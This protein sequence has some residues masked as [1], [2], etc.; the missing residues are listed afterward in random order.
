MH[1]IVD[2]LYRYHTGRENN[3]SNTVPVTKKDQL[4]LFW[5]KIYFHPELDPAF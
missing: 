2:I 1:V 3:S 5:T 4:K